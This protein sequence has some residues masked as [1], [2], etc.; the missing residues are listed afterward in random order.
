MMLARTGAQFGRKAKGCLR[1]LETPSWSAQ[2]HS[3]RGPLQ[4][5]HQAAS[6]SSY[7]IHTPPASSDKRPSRP[8]SYSY[9]RRSPSRTQNANAAPRAP[10]NQQQVVQL[11]SALHTLRAGL[12][13]RDL[14]SVWEATNTLARLGQTHRLS[15]RDRMDVVRLARIF[16]AHS[17][18]ASAIAE[19]GLRKDR[20]EQLWRD[21]YKV[22][23][24]Q[25]VRDSDLPRVLEHVR[26]ELECGC[27]GG[28]IEIYEYLLETLVSSTTT[29][30]HADNEASGRGNSSAVDEMDTAEGR[31][32]TRLEGLEELE[33]IPSD[34]EGAD[35]RDQPISTTP[36][37]GSSSLSNRI[38][39][40]HHS[41]FTD[42][43][44]LVAVAYAA[45][46]DVFGLA[47]TMRPLDFGQSSHP[48][49]E[50]RRAL[51][52]IDSVLPRVPG[53]ARES[54]NSPQEPVTPSQ[55]LRA[56]SVEYLRHA[57]LAR[58]LDTV[59]PDT[60]RL[61]RLLGGML[62]RRDVNSAWAHFVTAMQASAGAGAWLSLA[63]VE[64]KPGAANSDWT[65]SCWA[66]C[67]QGFITQGRA[68]LATS[69]WATMTA[70]GIAPT[71]RIYNALLGGYAKAFDFPAAER[72]WQEMR[73]RAK[74]DKSGLSPSPDAITFTTMIAAFFR[75]K[76]P[77]DAMRLFS[78]MRTDPNAWSG[79]TSPKV[80]LK[81]KEERGI[82]VPTY[83]A[84][85][86][87]LCFNNRTPEAHALLKEMREKGPAPAIGTLNTLLR[88]H[89]RARDMPALASVIRQIRPLGLEPDIVTFTTVLD[90]LMRV[91]SP[92]SAVG[93][94]VARVLNIMDQM[95]VRANAITYSAMIRAMVQPSGIDPLTGTPSEPRIEAALELLERMESAGLRST[96]VTYTALLAAVFS[97]RYTISQLHASGSI[98]SQFLQPRPVRSLRESAEDLSMLLQEHP[99]ISLA[100]ALLDRM[101]ARG[102]EPNRK[103]F[104]VL[105][106]GLLENGSP[107]LAFR[108]AFA[109]L[110]E[111]R[112]IQAP[113]AHNVGVGAGSGAARPQPNG[114]TWAIVLDAL[115]ARERGADDYE[116]AANGAREVLGM[117]KE[118]GVE[119]REGALGTLVHRARALA[120]VARGTKARA[121]T[122]EQMAR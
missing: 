24:K 20:R 13:S 101:R 91:G 4:Q 121:P 27:P 110:D 73:R 92:D 107:R 95:G 93:E 96:E 16:A 75:A 49:F 35:T 48:L 53:T 114:D 85:L 59:Q 99:A 100:L 105:L 45:Q 26:L 77:D 47:K 90:A 108:R 38:R 22:W 106:S 32:D 29:V 37:R 31:Q 122:A 17:N 102:L 117:M 80:G 111:M 44:I 19:D 65:E 42:I 7:Q 6:S 84:V 1:C 54:R 67:L 104:N 57:E 76:R 89:G 98:G 87:G 36:E 112:G 39:E 12:I 5:Q 8:S 46:N 113:G 61:A 66:V 18:E 40:I 14:E 82:P 51:R 30:E 25:A 116:L 3:L 78:E 41:V 72:T 63:E 28:A 64:S 9:P 50:S 109:L 120:S 60:D 115:C 74:E 68:D 11:N 70:R 34:T 58:G 10:L 94:I 62:G 23:G 21:R 43:L 86:H 118:D 33:T 15:L 69:V 52:V 71:Q 79:P 119:L 103:T 55:K 56:R 88:A 2:L 97:Y 81:G 83:N